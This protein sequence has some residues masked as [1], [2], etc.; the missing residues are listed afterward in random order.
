ME[1]HI[2]RFG[3]NWSTQ[4]IGTWLSTDAEASSEAPGIEMD[5]NVLFI[6]KEELYFV[7]VPPYT[8]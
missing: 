6:Y 3:E 2:Q 8:F 7:N 5:L 4:R 1:D